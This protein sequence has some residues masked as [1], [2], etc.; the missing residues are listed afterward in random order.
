[1]SNNYK[2]ILIMIPKRAL[3]KVPPSYKVEVRRLP[4]LLRDQEFQTTIT[5]F[6]N[7]IVF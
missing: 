2:N 7:S 1:M 6:L 5:E 4:P 3:S